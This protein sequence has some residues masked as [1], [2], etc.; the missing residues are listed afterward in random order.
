MTLLPA[1]RCHAA[2]ISQYNHNCFFQRLV[3]QKA[4]IQQLLLEFF[5]AECAASCNELYPD[6]YI[7]DFALVGD[8][9][10]PDE[11]LVIECVI[12]AGHLDS[13]NS[14]LLRARLPKAVCGRPCSQQ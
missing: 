3:D 6:G 2:A 8:S 11:V 10:A 7:I 12:I 4:R 9:E 14:A 1:R 5:A 13:S